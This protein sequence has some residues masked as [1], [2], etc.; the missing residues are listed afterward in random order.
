MALITKN[1]LCM[2][3]LCFLAFLPNLP[4]DNFSESS[5]SITMLAQAYCAALAVDERR[6]D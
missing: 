2:S 6:A 1:N 4:K 5:H 3:M